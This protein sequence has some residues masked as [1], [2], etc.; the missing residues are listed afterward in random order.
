MNHFE[1]PRR[2]VRLLVAY[3]GSGFS[4]FAANEGVTTVGR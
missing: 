2:M 1:E 4:G 3:D